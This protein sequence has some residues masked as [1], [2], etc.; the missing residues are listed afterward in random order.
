MP[1]VEADSDN[2]LTTNGTVARATWPGLTRGALSWA[3]RVGM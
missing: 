3:E 2:F 1:K